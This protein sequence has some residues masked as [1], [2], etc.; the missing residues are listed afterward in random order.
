MHFFYITHELN[1][2]AWKLKRKESLSCV[3]WERRKTLRRFNAPSHSCSVVFIF[4]EINKPHRG[5]LSLYSYFSTDLWYIWV[6]QMSSWAS[7]YCIS[8]LVWKRFLSAV[9]F[10]SFVILHW[11]L[12]EKFGQGSPL[13]LEDV[14]CFSQGHLKDTEKICGGQCAGWVSWPLSLFFFERGFKPSSISKIH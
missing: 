12:R 14:Q 13:Q 7:M 6:N 10:H 9:I 2:S 1:F 3:M 8:L 4:Q 5:F 11:C